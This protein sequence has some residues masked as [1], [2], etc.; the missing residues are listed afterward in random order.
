MDEATKV[1]IE[2]LKRIREEEAEKNTRHRK[3]KREKVERGEGA[4]L[5]EDVLKFLSRFIAYPSDHALIAHVLWI[6]H[7]HLMRAWESTPRL[8]FL[9]PEPASGKTRSMEVTELLVPK[10]VAAVNVTPAY[11]FRKVGGAADN[12]IRRDR[13]GL[14]PEGEGTRRIT[15]IAEFW[16]PTRRRGWS[17]PGARQDRRD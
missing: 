12:P 17:L 8:A 15:R 11:L 3:L 9:S 14:R 7:T 6:A 1:S 2:A 4:A 16:P 10:A 13:Y 5:L